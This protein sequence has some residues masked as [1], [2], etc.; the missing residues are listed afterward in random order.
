MISS[1]LFLGSGSS[2]GVPVIGCGCEVCQST[3]PFNKR[4]RSAA[5]LK[6]GDKRL[7]IDTGPDFRE[8]SLKNH[9]KSIDGVIYTH[10][11]Q[12]H[13]AGID[14]LRVFC[15]RKQGPIDCLMSEETANEMTQRFHY[16]FRTEPVENGFVKLLPHL[17]KGD[18]GEGEFLEVKYKFFSYS[19]MGMKVNGFR[20]GNLAYITDIRDY[21]ESIFAELE[22]IETLVISALRWVSTHMHLSVEEACQFAKRTGAKNVYLTHISHDLE[23]F[24]TTN[25]LPPGIKMSYDGLE[26]PF[27]GY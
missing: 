24:K 22:G 8:Q 19:Q 13:V 14:D 15:Y 9:L 20:F 18:S 1:L 10:A 5:L 21:D 27:I 17:L 11:H 6:I 23:H 25:E 4:S 3:S 12:D 7:V 16:L 2:L 26:I